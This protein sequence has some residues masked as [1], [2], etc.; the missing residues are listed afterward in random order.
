MRNALRRISPCLLPHTPFPQCLAYFI[1]NFVVTLVLEPVQ[2]QCFNTA[3]DKLRTDP[4]ITVRLGSSITGTAARE[5]CRGSQCE[6]GLP[7]SLPQVLTLV[8]PS[9]GA[10]CHVPWPFLPGSPT[11]PASQCTPSPCQAMARKQQTAPCATPS[12]TPSTR[13]PTARSTCG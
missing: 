11:P 5:G 12:P 2:K 1:Y 4:R 7:L 3:L 9:A 13:M 8:V 6:T 10:T